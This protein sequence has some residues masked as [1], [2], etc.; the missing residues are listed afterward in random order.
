[1]LKPKI[2]VVDD[3]HLQ[4]WALQERLTAW[5]YDVIQAADAAS[6]V[7]AFNAQLPDLV[8]LDLMLGADSGI[9]VLKQLKATDPSAVVI[10]VT[11]HGALDDAV[12]AFKMGL[13]DFV[14]KPI[15]FESFRMTVRYGLEARRLRAEVGRWRD[16]DRRSAVGAIIGESDALRR[17]LQTGEKVAV[18]AATT[19]LL[20]GESGTGKDLFARAIHYGSPRADGPFVPVNCAAL[21]EH[22]LESE[23]FGHERGA[24]T[25]ARALKKGLFEIADGGTVY[26][27]EIGEL[28]P[29]LQAKL[30]RVLETLSFR[31]VGGVRDITVDVRIIAASNRSLERAVEQ[32]EFRA[33]L[34]YRLGVIELHL[35]P[36]RD[37]PED[38]PQLVEHFVA[39]ITTRLRKPVDE[40]SPEAMRQLAAYAWP[41]NVREL[42][43]AI[44]RAVILEEGRRITTAHLHLGGERTAVQADAFTLP[45]EGVSLD[46]VEETLVR[47]AMT[48][49]GGNQTHAARLLGVGRDALRY[50]LKK[51]GIVAPDGAEQPVGVDR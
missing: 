38:I 7:D 3:E 1:M 26:L 23:L 47:Q 16:D 11:A 45:A 2:L 48:R 37:R 35:P 14:A 13:F 17:A 22:L 29:G 32:Q 34:Y 41:G 5:G 36:L 50:K 15:D 24:F 31:R 28:K 27:D 9:D 20:Q 43:N 10:M 4:R 49:A 18:S 44:E 6:A 39:E 42:R 30:L 51:F 19:V 12:S 40:V 25:D 33:D 8:L 21:P 46:R